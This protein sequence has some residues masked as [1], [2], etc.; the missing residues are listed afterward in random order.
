MARDVDGRYRFVGAVA[1]GV[2]EEQRFHA[3]ALWNGAPK[4]EPERVVDP[5]ALAVELEHDEAAERVVEHHLESIADF[6]R[7]ALGSNE[8]EAFSRQRRAREW[9][10][11]EFCAPQGFLS[12]LPF[13]FVRKVIEASER[14]RNE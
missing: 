6:H 12:E 5:A 2:R 4:R 1:R 3:L 10:P 14:W 7:R 11:Q 13:G 8:R 9:L